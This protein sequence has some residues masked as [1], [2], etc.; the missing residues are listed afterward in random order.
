MQEGFSSAD[1]GRDGDVDQDLILSL[2]APFLPPPVDRC[3]G[4]DTP[5]PARSSSTGYGSFSTPLG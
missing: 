5:V 4:G 3:S 1:D 2:V